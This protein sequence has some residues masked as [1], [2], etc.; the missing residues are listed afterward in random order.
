MFLMELSTGK[1]ILHVGDFRAQSSMVSNPFISAKPI[2]TIYLDTTYCNPKYNFPLQCDV[3]D[4]VV[5]TTR[6]FLKE[7]RKTLIVSGT[8]SVGK[9]KVFKAIAMDQDFKI[10]VTKAKMTLLNCLDDEDLKKR[11]TLDY[12]Q[13]QIHVLPL[14]GITLKVRTS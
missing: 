3:I 5:K 11:L 13:A 2:H 6:R 10:G 8:Y 9:E 14:G 1:R 4:F 7:N 12:S